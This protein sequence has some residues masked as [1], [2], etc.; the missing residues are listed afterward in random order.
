MTEGEYSRKY[1]ATIQRIQK[2]IV[3]EFGPA[4]GDSYIQGG[5]NYNPGRLVLLLK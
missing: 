2:E 1:N 3:R 5:T 4:P